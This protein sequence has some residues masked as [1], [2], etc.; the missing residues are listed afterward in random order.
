MSRP[1]NTSGW[2]LVFS[3]VS[4]LILGIFGAGFLAPHNYNET[5]TTGGPPLA[6]G[7]YK[8]VTAS[9]VEQLTELRKNRVAAIKAHLTRLDNRGTLREI[10]FSEENDLRVFTYTVDTRQQL[11]QIQLTG[12]FSVSNDYAQ[13]TGYDLRIKS[14]HLFIG[15]RSSQEGVQQWLAD[16]EQL[17]QGWDAAI[18][19][20]LM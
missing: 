13:T 12:S 8:V 9:Q 15:V 1:G 17:L 6:P 19:Q 4:I 3:V 14:P 11:I 7:N 16:L 20:T 10:V 5:V 18:K 2:L